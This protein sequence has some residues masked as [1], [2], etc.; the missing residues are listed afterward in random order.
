VVSQLALAV[1]LAVGAGI[2]V[3]TV[4]NLYQIDPGFR[5]QKV[6]TMRVDPS[7]AAFRTQESRVAFWQDFLE[8]VNELPG[9]ISAGAVPWLPLGG[10][11]PVWSYLVEGERA[12]SISDAP[13]APIQQA[14]PGYLAALG[15]TLVRGRFFDAD[16]RADARPVAVINEAMARRHWAGED[17][18]GKRIRLY[19]TG[20]PWMEIVGVV[21]NV[22]DNALSR[23]ARPKYYWPHAQ[24]PAIAGWCMLSMTLVV[25]AEGDPLRLVGPIRESLRGIDNLAP[26]SR[27]VTMEQLTARSLGDK[28]FIMILLS[29]FGLVALFLASVGVYG[30]ISSAV[31]QRTREIGLR[32]ALGAS[33]PQVVRRIL[34]EGMALTGGGL[35]FGLLGVAVLNHVFRSLV[36]GVS[37]SDPVTCGAVAIVI[38]IAAG[39]ASLLPAWRASRVDPVVALRSE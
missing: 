21:S 16:D 26:V 28:H 5:P 7:P 9:V 6:L 27:V 25:R 3:R 33:G 15:L 39:G 19:G 36:F 13:A 37:T 1:L 12:A 34:L 22:R 31:S 23:E 10:G 30:V 8:S 18:I 38:T 20:R 17:P 29:L 24:A 35:G 32:V 2:M 14:T 11:F 4:A